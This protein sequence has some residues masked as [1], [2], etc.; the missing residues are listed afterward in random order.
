MDIYYV[1][2]KALAEVRA[3]LE[4]GN[5]KDVVEAD[6]YSL[7]YTEKLADDEIIVPVDLGGVGEK[8]E[9]DAEKMVYKL[10]A[11]GAAQ[12]FIKAA[13]CFDANEDQEPEGE[14]PQPMTVFERMIETGAREWQPSD[15]IEKAILTKSN[16]FH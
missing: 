7:A 15:F 3:K 5:G 6:V 14:R 16:S 2:K 1:S 13:D 12:E 9:N 8:F 10:G 11:K 4:D